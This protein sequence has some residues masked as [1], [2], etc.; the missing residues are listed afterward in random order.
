VIALALQPPRL[1]AGRL[2]AGMADLDNQTGDSRLDGV[3]AL[4]GA[5]LEQSRRVS[6]MDRG[7]VLRALTKGGAPPAVIAEADAVA[8]ARASSAELVLVPALRPVRGGYELAVQVLDLVRGRTIFTAREGAASEGSIYTAA[9]RL[10]VRVR[11]AL[12]EEASEAPR[13]PTPVAAYAPANP[14]ALR[15]H[16][17]G[18]RLQAEYDYEGA[19]AKWLEAIAL[20]P[21]FPLPRLSLLQGIVG[22][23]VYLELDEKAARE[24]A[25]ALRRDLARLPESLRPWAETLIVKVD[26]G[27]ANHTEFLAALD[28]AI[29]ARPEQAAPYIVAAN[30]L[31][32]RRGDAEA[33]RPYVDRA[34]ELS[35]LAGLGDVVDY[36]VL[37]ERFDEALEL[38][39]KWSETAPGPSS[40]ANLA[41]V[42]TARGE[43][44]QALSVRRE[45]E[46][47][48][49]DAGVFVGTDVDAGLFEELDAA[50]DLSPPSAGHV[51]FL[52]A[53]L[54][55]LRGRVREALRV[56]DDAPQPSG[57]PRAA[58]A[59]PRTRAAVL[60][61]RG[62]LEAVDR[63]V[64]DAFLVAGPHP[65]LAWV[66]AE[67]GNVALA[68]SVARLAPD[69]LIGYRMAR[70]IHDWKAGD[71]ED[72]LAELGAITSPAS[73]LY[74]GAI[75]AEQGRHR[76][77]VEAFRR[78]RRLRHGE[79]STPS[80]RLTHWLLPR[81]LYLEA[82]SLEAVG[83]RDEARRV[84]TFLLR[85]WARADPDLPLLAKAKELERR[86]RAAGVEVR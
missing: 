79:F 14:D 78:Y 20:D 10:A 58:G 13:N 28:A 42:H 36:L 44:E 32:L 40:F 49:T 66:L 70:A 56:L 48:W 15:L 43:L 77:A 72:A 47:R 60:L 54:L 4:F 11:R 6:L 24:Q 64:D 35:P 25:R 86:T 52:D 18:E 21:S 17:E 7:T 12:A 26:G 8:A 71:P 57:D 33:A 81:S 59:F 46:Q 65:V 31:L 83:E 34:V 51:R 75:L 39:R 41:M 5:A 62:D 30:E 76:D 68:R 73:H 50:L 19:K 45:M 84:V 85:L 61:A 3:G 82:A 69:R 2:V 74:R 38:A 16:I 37:T 22:A 55:A 9:D 27:Y 1:R 80:S 53:E 29:A 63:A 23:F 67:A